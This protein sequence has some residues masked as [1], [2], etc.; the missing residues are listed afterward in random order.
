MNI[1][2]LLNCWNRLMENCMDSKVSVLF[3]SYLTV[4]KTT[5]LTLVSGQL[6]SKIDGEIYRKISKKS[7]RTNFNDLSHKYFKLKRQRVYNL[8]RA[9]YHSTN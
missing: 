3:K 7:H 8:F 2:N 6:E 5:F 1:A 4:N 9:P